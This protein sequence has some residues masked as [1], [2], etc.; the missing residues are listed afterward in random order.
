[1][2]LDLV[3]HLDHVGMAIG[4]GWSVRDGDGDLLAM[5]AV[6]GF[7]QPLTLTAAAAV[8]V[9]AADDHVWIQQTLPL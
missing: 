5:G 8:L 7:G 3:L 9:E 6:P 4:G 1:M 2:R